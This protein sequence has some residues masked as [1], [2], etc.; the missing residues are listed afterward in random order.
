MQTV[1]V[2]YFGHGRVDGNQNDVFVALFCIRS[3][4]TQVDIVAE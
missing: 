1:G 4:Q 2:G 3:N